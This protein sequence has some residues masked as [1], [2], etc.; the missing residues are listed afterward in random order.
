MA[1]SI[2]TPQLTPVQQATVGRARAALQE[3]H[4]TDVHDLS[5]RI[6]QLEWWLGDIL[7]LV[8]SITGVTDASQ[9]SP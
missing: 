3:E 2:T 5:V 6:G 1:A 9:L 7:A 4:G 8:D